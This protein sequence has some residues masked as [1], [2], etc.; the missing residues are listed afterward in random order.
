MSVPTRVA[1]EGVGHSSGQV[2]TLHIGFSGQPVVD[3]LTPTDYLGPRNRGK[4]P[5]KRPLS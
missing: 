3:S 5:P 2:I 1:Q 4:Q